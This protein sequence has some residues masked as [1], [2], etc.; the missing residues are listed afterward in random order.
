MR[1]YVLVT[2][3][4][5]DYPEVNVPEVFVDRVKAVDAW[6][7]SVLEAAG[8]PDNDVEPEVLIDVG[9]AAD[10]FLTD[11]EKIEVGWIVNNDHSLEEMVHVQLF[12]VEEG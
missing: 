7:G 1:R 12:A 11:V 9:T 2:S 6:R 10:E 8:Y 5:Y 3:H 4:A